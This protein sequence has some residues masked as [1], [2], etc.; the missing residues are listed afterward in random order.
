MDLHPTPPLFHTRKYRSSPLAQ[1]SMPT[2][3]AQN[4]SLS[5]PSLPVRWPVPESE[6]PPLR[7][8][9]WNSSKKYAR[10]RSLLV[11]CKG[12]EYYHI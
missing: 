7:D 3:S 4:V 9:V 6:P 11:R 12:L 8:F 2:T 10:R 5:S 1:A